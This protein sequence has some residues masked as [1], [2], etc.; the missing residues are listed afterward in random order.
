MAALRCFTE[1]PHVTRMYSSLYVCICC[2]ED[3]LKQGAN[4]S[5][6]RGTTYIQSFY[7]LT[8]LNK[9][10]DVTCWG[11]ISFER[12]VSPCPVA[13]ADDITVCVFLQVTHRETGE[14]MVMKELI[15]FDDETQRTFLK[16]VGDITLFD[17]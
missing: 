4:I 12:K 10:P 15:R 5:F 1:W 11:E 16:E 2:L 3:A 8:V 6:E 14:V 9:F 17:P 7:T 13:Q